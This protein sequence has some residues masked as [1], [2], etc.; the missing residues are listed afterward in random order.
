[1]VHATAHVHPS[2]HIAE[3]AK[4]WNWVQ[5]RENADIGENTILSKSVYVDFGVKIG[6]NVKIQN[7]VSVYHGVTIEDGVFIGPHVCFTNDKVPRAINPDGTQK[8]T[9]DWEV[10]STVIRFGASLGANATILP[11]VT[12][13]R[14]ALV[15]A[16][17]VVTRDVPD[18]GLA[19]GCPA[20]LI[21]YV[22]ECGQRMREAGSRGVY[23]CEKCAKEIRIR[24]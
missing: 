18:Y 8:G 22:C 19:V 1:M 20:R 11:G 24:E 14:F 21:G 17:A 13:G 2:A 9:A 5:V 16:G 12:V 7:N 23:R 15:G 6:K 10:S 3:S 4:V